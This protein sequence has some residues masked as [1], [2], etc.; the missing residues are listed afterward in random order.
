MV[1]LKSGSVPAGASAD[2]AQQDG[3]QVGKRYA[4]D[5]LKLELLCTNAGTG[6]LAANG[7]A[8]PMKAAKSLPSSD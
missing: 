8:L 5:D 2:P 1:D 6:T 7:N 3:T 4:D